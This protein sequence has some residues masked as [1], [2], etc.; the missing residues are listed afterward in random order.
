MPKGGEWLAE[1][2]LVLQGLLER[3]K[4]GGLISV[5]FYNRHGLVMQNLIL[6]NLARIRK[7]ELAG[8]GDSLT[9]IN[10]LDTQEVIDWLSTDDFEQLSFSGVRCFY[11]FM[12][13]WVREKKSLEELIEVEM[14]L[15]QIEAYRSTARYQHVV[16]RRKN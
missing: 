5:L 9:P 16:Y 12:P 1:P 2:Q 13:P 14:S 8:W 10:P 6:G 15:N 7:D 4:P 3:V 11:D